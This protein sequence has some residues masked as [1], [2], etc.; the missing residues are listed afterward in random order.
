MVR[1]LRGDVRADQRRL[2]AGKEMVAGKRLQAKRA[3]T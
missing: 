3:L 1:V 2:S